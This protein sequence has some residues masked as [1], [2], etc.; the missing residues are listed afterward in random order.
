[1]M[2][3]TTISVYSLVLQLHKTTFAKRKH[4]LFLTGKNLQISFATTMTSTVK[5]GAIEEIT[6]FG[7]Q[8][9]SSKK[10]QFLPWNYI[11][12]HTSFY[13]ASLYCTSQILCFL[14]FEGQWNPVWSIFPTVLN[15]FVSLCHFW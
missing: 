10:H 4:R 8:G 9:F 6:A 3:S 7:I 15:Y 2:L 13:S 5:T 12:R 1:M 14:Q 11:S